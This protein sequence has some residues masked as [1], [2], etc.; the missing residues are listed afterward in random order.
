M[1]AS[2]RRRKKGTNTTIF[3]VAKK[4]GVSIATVSLALRDKPQIALKTRLLVAKAAKLLHYQPNLAAQSLSQRQTN[5]I[6]ICGWFFEQ[7]LEQ[8]AYSTTQIFHGILSRLK[9]T[10]YAVY[11]VNWHSQVYEHHLSQIDFSNQ[12]F[13]CGSIWIT[14]PLNSKQ[15]KEALRFPLPLVLAEAYLPGVDSV[16]VDNRLGGYLGA[17]RLLEAHP[18]GR[19]V[20]ITGEPLFLGLKARLE[21]VKKAAKEFGIGWGSVTV[22]KTTTFGFLDGERIA[23]ELAAK[24][25]KDKV[26]L[27]VFCLAGDWCAMGILNG[28]KKEGIKVPD[29]VALLGY[30]GKLEAAYVSPSISTVQ[31]PL[32]DL[33]F[34]SADALLQR[35]EGSR[36]PAKHLVL[37][38]SFVKRDSA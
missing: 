35:I 4:A 6:A 8:S 3:D 23:T 7:S 32:F 9:G 13:I 30:D 5:L 34:S 29:Q 21:G 19:L 22:Y 28:L 17:K 36:V 18:Q 14:A 11:I 24:I 12:T 38:P 37:A 25:L 26:T 16:V 20:V 27:A 31:Q 15:K 1:V 2:R 33:G 10:R